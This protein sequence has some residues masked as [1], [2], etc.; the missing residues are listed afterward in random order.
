MSYF[1]IEHSKNYVD[2]VVI[3][4]NNGDTVFGEYLNM[5]YDEMKNSD[6]LD[7]FVVAVMDCTKEADRGQAIVTL[8][9]DDDI[10]IWSIIISNDGENVR[11]VLVDWKK[12]GKNYRYEPS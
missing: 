5:S 2:H 11:Y 9:G 4:D 6:T 8:V 12:D 3:K 7:E 1:A 10:F